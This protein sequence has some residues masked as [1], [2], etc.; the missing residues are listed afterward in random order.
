M[1]R[2]LSQLFKNMAM[3]PAERYLSQATNLQDLERRQKD[4]SRGRVRF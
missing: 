4:I 1:T 3:T 2:W